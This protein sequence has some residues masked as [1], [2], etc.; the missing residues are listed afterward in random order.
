MRYVE[1][2][3]PPS[4]RKAERQNIR[5]RGGSDNSC[6]A[7]NGLFGTCRKG[8][9]CSA[10]VGDSAPIGTSDSAGTTTDRRRPFTI[11]GTFRDV[12]KFLRA[13]RAG[14]SAGV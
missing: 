12:A 3:I 8:F 4:P 10:A 1:P 5:G 9:R 7:V 11:S 14:Q 2:F 13:W 6:V